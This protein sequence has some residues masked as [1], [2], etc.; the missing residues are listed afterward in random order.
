MLSWKQ[1]SSSGLLL[2]PVLASLIAGSAS[3]AAEDPVVSHGRMAKLVEREF[4][5]LSD[6]T[7]GPRARLALETEKIKWRHGETEHFV[8]H[9][10][11]LTEAQKLARQAEFYYEKIQDDLAATSDLLS[12]KSHLILFS[13]ADQWQ[14]FATEAEVP[15]WSVGFAAGRELFLLV[16]AG[17]TYLSD[18]LAHEMTH[19]VFFRFV[20]KRVPLWLNEGFAEYESS[21]AYAKFKGIGMKPPSH[22]RVQP[23]E[24]TTL[25]SLQTYPSDPYEVV[26]FYIESERLVRFLMTR[27]SKD[28]FVPFV[29][30]LAD[31][32]EFEAAL[33][34]IYRYR[35]PED[36]K[37]QLDRF[38]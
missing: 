26:R 2:W 10:Q 15:R 14:S 32:K 19:L 23:M 20:P 4:S 1:I 18:R 31:G 11:R 13:R 25:T 3:R 35:K 9:F 16:E 38:Q 12:G 29:N 30:L 7:L 21:A 27:H 22:E 5:D 6:K 17:A 8:Y 33:R 36:L 28:Q 34:Q 24:I 37:K